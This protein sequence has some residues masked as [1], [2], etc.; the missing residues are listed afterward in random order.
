MLA[1]ARTLLGIH[2]SQT[3]LADGMSVGR[4][5]GIK[6]PMGS[7]IPHAMSQVELARYKSPNSMISGFLVLVGT[8]WAPIGAPMGEMGENNLS[9]F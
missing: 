8:Q 7:A 3:A 2:W 5:R 4:I 9:D 1:R 6:S